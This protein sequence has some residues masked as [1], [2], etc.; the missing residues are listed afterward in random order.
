MTNDYSMEELLDFLDHTSNK[1]LMPAATAQALAV[2]ARNVFG[3]LDQDEQNNIGALDLEAIIKRFNNK[4]ARDFNPGSLKEYGRRV[5]RAIE[6]YEKWKENP[7][8]FS[9][10]TRTARKTRRESQDET[11]ARSLSTPIA[12]EQ[13]APNRTGTFQSSFLIGPGRVVTLSN[14]PIDLTSAEAERLAQLVR[15]LAVG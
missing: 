10:K 15:Q 14:I 6:L 8:N 11:P 3:V 13:A 7:A 1:G 9:I 4:R 5:R 2:A 12:D